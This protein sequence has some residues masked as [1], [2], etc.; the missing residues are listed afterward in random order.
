VLIF[1]GLMG[2]C[3]AGALFGGDRFWLALFSRR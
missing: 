3:G 1:I 2:G